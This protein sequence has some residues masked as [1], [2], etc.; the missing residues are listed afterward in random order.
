MM[1][2][3]K[4]LVWTDKKIKFL[5]MAHF[6][7]CAIGLIKLAM[8]VAGV[9]YEEK[10]L[11]IG[12]PILGNAIFHSGIGKLGSFLQ[13]LLGLFLLAIVFFIPIYNT[14]YKTTFRRSFFV[15]NAI[16]LFFYFFLNLIFTYRLWM[17]GTSIMHW[18]PEW[19]L[20]VT[21][22]PFACSNLKL[23]QLPTLS[24]K[25]IVF[26][27]SILL[28]QLFFIFKPL[29]LKPM[30]IENDYMDMPGQTVLKSGEWV[31][32]TRYINEHR[33]G[34]IFK[35]DPR[36]DQGKTQQPGWG[37]YVKINSS[38]TLDLFLQSDKN[39]ARYR[40]LYYPK[41]QSLTVRDA[42][43]EN[44]FSRLSYSYSR[45]EDRIKLN[46][47]YF[48]SLNK[49][50]EASSRVYTPEEWDF[51][52][53]NKMELI[54]QGKTGWFFYH[55]N[56]FFEPIFAVSQGAV[57]QP[58]VYGWF[59]TMLFVKILP[60]LGG[61]N[62]QNYFK[63]FFS[64][65][66]LYY[67]SFLAIVFVIF[68]RIEYVA[69]GFML[70]ISAL[71]AL[72]MQSVVLA[73][74]FNPVRHFLDIFVLASFYLYT[75]KRSLFWLSVSLLLSIIS[76]FFNK[77]FGIFLLMALIGA[78]TVNQFFDKKLFSLPI[79][80]SYAA[81]LLGLFTYLKLIPGKFEGSI[82]MLFGVGSPFTASYI[83]RWLLLFALAFYLMVILFRS[84]RDTMNYFWVAVIFY[85]QLLLIYFLWFPLAHHFFGMAIPFIFLALCAIHLIIR[86]FHFEQDEKRILTSLIGFSFLLFY[87]P[88][89]FNFYGEAKQYHDN[90]KYHRLYQWNFE[91]ARF[92]STMDPQLFERAVALIKKYDTQPDIYMISKYETI[93]PVLAGKY[94][95]FPYP[96]LLTN[97]INENAEQKVL[98][99]IL[100]NKPTYFFVDADISRGY[101]YDYYNRY[102]PVSRYLELYKYSYDRAATLARLSHFYQHIKNKYHPIASS[103]LITV[104]QK[105]DV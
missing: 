18:F 3:Y 9:I 78:V 103:E 14:Y 75:R 54:D 84:V 79:I 74:G 51:I 101:N 76:I 92:N 15:N 104:Y 33:V 25:W 99:V 90:F 85:C 23:S 69:L 91:T 29:I 21:V 93:L 55:H 65:Y 63:L 1:T 96:E 13:Y 27:L 82:Y 22:L 60:L 53:K 66:P 46:E 102:D 72:G 62:Y 6:M 98:D 49:K 8:I 71:F 26:I 57:D 40:Y 48:L 70:G 30:L 58:F 77:D 50:L 105:N 39:D 19:L 35:Y 89:A 88:S 59:A 47:F 44:E 67:L 52:S 97:L 43:A 38:P 100:K 10:L 31:D 16:V 80:F 11:G 28:L 68:R 32:N 56:Y 61:V 36:I 94:T 7:I 86:Y 64:I 83:V 87:L 5:L 24:A 95:A 34:G 20:F 81:G 45:A 12:V 41:E 4:N 73:P 2:S 42:M 37:A 17:S